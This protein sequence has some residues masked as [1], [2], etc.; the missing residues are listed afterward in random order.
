VISYTSIMVEAYRLATG[1]SIQDSLT[2]L[3]IDRLVDSTEI[4]PLPEEQVSFALDLQADYL[5]I[6]QWRKEQQ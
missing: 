5:G 2:D 3:G 4:L 1:K 6:T